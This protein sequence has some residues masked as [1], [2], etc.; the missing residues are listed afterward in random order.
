MSDQNNGRGPNGEC[1]CDWCTKFYPLLKKIQPLITEEEN[2]ILDRYLSKMEMDGV[3]AV[4]WKEKFYGTWP[5]TTVEDLQ[6]HIK[7]LEERI[8]QLQKEQ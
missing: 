8:K 6:H 5:G 4:F 3:D 7:K 2:T 1:L